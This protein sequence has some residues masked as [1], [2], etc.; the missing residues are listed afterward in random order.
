[1]GKKRT[2]LD[3]TKD[4]LEVLKNY[5]EVKITHLIYKSN[6]SNNSIKPYL[7]ELTENNLVEEVNEKDKKYFKITQKGNAFLNEYSKIR[8]FADSYGLDV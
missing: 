6:L 5:R 4:I 7:K 8:V 2:K 3:V 1:M